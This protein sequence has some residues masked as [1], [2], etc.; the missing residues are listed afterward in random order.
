MISVITPTRNEEANV[1]T[2]HAAVAKVFAE[3]LPNYTYEHIFA[4]NGS[5]DQ[6]R[7][8]LRGIARENANVRVIL[9]SRNFGAEASMF[10]AL[11]STRGDAVMVM[12]PA[13]LQDPAELLPTFVGHWEE[14]YRVV[15]GIRRRRD[16]HRV[17]F[18]MRQIF[19]RLVAR[20]S[21]ISIPVDV[22]EYQLIDRV[23]VEALRGFDDR[24]PYLRGMIASCGFKAK[25]FEYDVKRRVGGRSNLNLYRLVDIALN[26]LTA[27]SAAPLRVAL[28]AGM[29]LAGLSV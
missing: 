22:G 23:V 11:R 5:T 18:A 7:E 8:L 29:A 16:E 26:G 2:C 24:R 14:G 28:F 1:A 6:T 21:D 13:D 19:Y 27:F 25:G 12:I 15:Y 10:N 3:S 4:D 9:N 20:M 17:I